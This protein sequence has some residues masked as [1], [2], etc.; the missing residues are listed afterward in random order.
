MELVVASGNRHKVCEIS[1][2]LQHLPAQVKSLKD[3]PD[4]PPVVE[5]G[6]TFEIN[7]RKKAREIYDC[8]QIP[9]LAD[10]SGLEVPALNNQPGVFSARFAGPNATD[11]DNNNL[12]LERLKGL[13]ADQR[14]ARFVCSLCFIIDNKEYK[15]TGFAT[16]VI[17]EHP[18]GNSGFGY[19]PLF[20]VPQ[21]NKTFAELETNEKSLISHRGQAMKKFKFFL[22]EY[23]KKS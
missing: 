11:L 17:L 1:K 22:N 5:D 7:A 4:I 20:F 15:F 14:T 21:K 23:F 3:Y 10:D 19:D 13:S 12:L 2:L 18:R 8:L 6:S 9:V 16:G